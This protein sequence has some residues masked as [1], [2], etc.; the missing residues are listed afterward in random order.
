MIGLA[1][2][3]AIGATLAFG[4]SAWLQDARTQGPPS[5]LVDSAQ[6]LDLCERSG[7][8]VVGDNSRLR[9]A[10]RT[11]MARL[12]AWLRTLEEPFRFQ[13]FVNEAMTRPVPSMQLV[14]YCVFDTP[15]QKKGIGPDPM[16]TAPEPE[17]IPIDRAVVLV[18]ANGA[19]HHLLG[20]SRNP[21]TG[22]AYVSL[23]RPTGFGPR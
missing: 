10:Y 20:G 16:S 5:E 6:A 4:G 12:D 15:E 13:P 22:T 9:A 23:E 7:P 21:E 11:D 3:A 1:L 18:E 2:A 8:I 17:P 14:A 19:A